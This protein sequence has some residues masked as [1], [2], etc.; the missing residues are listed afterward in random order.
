MKGTLSSSPLTFDYR[1]YQAVTNVRFQSSCGSCW[2]FSSTGVYESAL[3]LYNGITKD[4]AEQFALECDQSS[5]GCNGGWPYFALQTLSNGVP[6]ETSYPYQNNDYYFGSSM[7]STSNKVKLNYTVT[8]HD[9]FDQYLTVEQIQNLLYTYGPLSVSVHSAHNSFRYS[10]GYVN[11][12]PSVNNS[13][14]D[15]VVLLVGYTT[16]HW[17]IKNSWGTSWGNNGYAYV[18]KVW[19]CGIKNLVNFLEVDGPR[20]SGNTPNPIECNQ[21]ITY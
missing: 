13:V 3:I 6:E 19:D 10:S 15:H 7:C 12:C 21:T 5:G 16:T 1:D 20:Y 14:T 2:A 4:L 11:S 8:V 18:D 17:I 9:Y